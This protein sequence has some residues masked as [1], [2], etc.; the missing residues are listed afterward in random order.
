[1][2]RQPN[3]RDAAC[4]ESNSL[5][6]QEVD[7]GFVG[8]IYGPCVG[9]RERTE[10]VEWFER[11]GNARGLRYDIRK[12]RVEREAWSRFLGGCKAVIGAESG[13]YYLND[14]GC[15]SERAR[16]YNLFEN[17]EASFGEVF[18]RFYRDAPREVSGKHLVA[19]F[20]ADRHQDLP[21]SDAGHYNGILDADRHY[22]ALAS[23]LRN[24]DDA[25]RRFQDDDYRQQMVDETYDYVIAEHTYANRISELIETV[26][27]TSGVRVSGKSLSSACVAAPGRSRRNRRSVGAA[28]IYL[29]A[30][31]PDAAEVDGGTSL[32][33][34]YRTV[35]AW[36]ELLIG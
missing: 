19:P 22:I 9:D 5:L 6:T 34:C 32:L 35:D 31:Q 29:R 17:R 1:M 21:D 8:D 7:I 36:S 27:S 25:L 11:C 26:T 30:S 20:R 18:D 13:T 28:R 15:L 4:A 14:R 2:R 23:D 24:I 10:L 3:R 12:E 16:A 33:A